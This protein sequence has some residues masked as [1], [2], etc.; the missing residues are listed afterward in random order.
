MWNGAVSLMRAGCVNITSQTPGGQ[1][2]EGFCDCRICDFTV[3]HINCCGVAGV[4]G[5]KGVE[6]ETCKFTDKRQ[7]GITQRLRGGYAYSTGHVG[8][9]IVHYAIDNEGG[10]VVCCGFCCFY[11]AALVDADINDNAAR[12]HSSYQRT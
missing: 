6:A 12:F 10:F 8:D 3:S 11:A 1:V 9:T 4:G 2:G 5:G 7:C